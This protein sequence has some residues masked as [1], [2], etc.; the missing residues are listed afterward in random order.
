MSDLIELKNAHESRMKIYAENIRE[1][2]AEYGPT[3]CDYLHHRQM[4]ESYHRGAYNAILEVENLL[5]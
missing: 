3:P 1:H 5:G 4:M 2:I